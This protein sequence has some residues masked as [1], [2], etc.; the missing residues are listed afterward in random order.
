MAAT[1]NLTLSTRCTFGPVLLTCTSGGDPYPLAGFSAFAEVRRIATQRNE[2]KTYGDIVLDLA[3]VIAAD[4][5]AGLIMIPSIDLAIT[6]DL[7]PMVA[8]WDLILQDADGNRWPP[9]IAGRF[10]ITNTVTQPQ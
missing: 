4:D 6:K 2:L 1:V 10:T 3:P 9:S 8:E 7:C 5:A